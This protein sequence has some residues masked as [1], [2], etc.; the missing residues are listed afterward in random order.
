V[1]YD[2]VPDVAIRDARSNPPDITLCSGATGLEIRK[3]HNLNGPL[4]NAG[5]VDRDGVN[6]LLIGISG[7][8]IVISGLTGNTLLQWF[9]HNGLVK[10]G[11][12]VGNCGDLDADGWTY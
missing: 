11:A 3:F 9:D 7:A 10:L 8:P 6:D 1:D 5:D 12:S 4:A 2:G